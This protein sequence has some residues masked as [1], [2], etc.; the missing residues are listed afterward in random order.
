MAYKKQSAHWKTDGSNNKLNPK[1]ARYD[2]L[3][4]NLR[5]CIDDKGEVDSPVQRKIKKTVSESEYSSLY[6]IIY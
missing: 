2:R 5:S 4:T 1:K 6:Y 3:D